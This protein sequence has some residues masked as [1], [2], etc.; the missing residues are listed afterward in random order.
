MTDTI[1]EIR[2]F[3]DIDGMADFAV[4]KWNEISEKEITGKGCFTVAL[5]GGNTPLTLYRKLSGEKTLPWSKTQVL[6]RKSVV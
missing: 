5:S 3:K 4:E 6:D 2:I 1:K